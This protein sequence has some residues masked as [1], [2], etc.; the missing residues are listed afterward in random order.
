[1][2]G[3]TT[4]FS[5]LLLS[6]AALL[7]LARS[8]LGVVLEVPAEPI[9]PAQHLLGRGQF[10]LLLLFNAQRAPDLVDH[11]LIGRRDA[12]ADRLLAARLRTRPRNS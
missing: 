10:G 5:L 7:L 8:R 11:I 2:L 6:V 12:A 3:S 9:A 1:V 4:G